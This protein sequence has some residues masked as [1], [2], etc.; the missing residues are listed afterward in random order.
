MTSFK[1]DIWSTFPNFLASLPILELSF[2]SSEFK[3]VTF[4]S[5]FY[6]LNIEVNSEP[7]QIS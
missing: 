2:R 7:I 1:Y 6:L 4:S 3:K 5:F